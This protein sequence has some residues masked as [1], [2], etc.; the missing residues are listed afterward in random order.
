MLKQGDIVD[1]TIDRIVQYGLYLS[2]G[3]DSFLVLAVDADTGN[4]PI[5][6]VFNTG[7]RVRIQ[8]M[9]HSAE[10]DLYRARIAKGP[11]PTS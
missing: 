11:S 8:V 7:E 2:A 9:R 1:A 10:D 5:E 3:G 4:T 6:D